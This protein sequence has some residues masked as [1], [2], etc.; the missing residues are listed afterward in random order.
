MQPL[1][2]LFNDEIDVYQLDGKINFNIESIEDGLIFISKEDVE[3]RIGYKLE[4]MMYLTES[5]K[6][7]DFLVTIDYEFSGGWDLLRLLESDQGIFFN[8]VNLDLPI[9]WRVI[10]FFILDRDNSYGIIFDHLFKKL[11]CCYINYI[12]CFACGR[13][14]KEVLKNKNEGVEG[15]FQLH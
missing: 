1:V 6:I 13:S 2:K 4:Q 3:E 7:F 8:F 15:S 14:T 12:F 10:G 11:S 5:Y 9:P